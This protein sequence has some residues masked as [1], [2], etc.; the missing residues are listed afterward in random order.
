MTQFLSLYFAFNLSMY[1]T[2]KIK[3]KRPRKEEQRKTN[4]VVS[5]STHNEF[6]PLCD[7]VVGICIGIGNTTTKSEE[8]KREKPKRK[9]NIIKC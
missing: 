2:I 5:F 3:C 9:K 8:K 7:D 6:V 4:V 1:H